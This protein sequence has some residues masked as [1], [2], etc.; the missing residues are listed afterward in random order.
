LDKFH[1]NRK[2]YHY[3]NLQ[4][5]TINTLSSSLSTN[6]SSNIIKLKRVKLRGNNRL[7]NNK[8]DDDNV[9]KSYVRLSIRNDP[10]SIPNNSD[11]VVDTSNDNETKKIPIK[12]NCSDSSFIAIVDET[13]KKDKNQVSKT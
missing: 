10:K 5:N 6:Q 2:L 11:F 3:K 12:S 1:F 9:Q 4:N 13:V 7:R 8:S